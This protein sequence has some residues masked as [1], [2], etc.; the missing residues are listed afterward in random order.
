MRLP[1]PCPGKCRYLICRGF[2]TLESTAMTN[3][4]GANYVLPNWFVRLAAAMMVLGSPWAIWVTVQ[5]QEHSTHFAVMNANRF[6][7]KDGQDVWKEI[8]VIRQQMATLPS[9][10]RIDKLDARSQEILQRI[11]AMETLIRKKESS[12]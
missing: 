12:P 9:T 10:D 8:G 7:A 3:N 4:S 2:F 6:T 1:L 11:V 5:I